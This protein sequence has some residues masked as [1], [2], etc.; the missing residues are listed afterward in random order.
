M[1]ST[2]SGTISTGAVAPV[3]TRN[4]K[5]FVLVVFAVMTPKLT[6]VHES[7]AARAFWV[8]KVIQGPLTVGQY[9]YVHASHLYG[10]T[11]AR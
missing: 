3:G 11:P 2:K 10:P 8:A 9:L 1:S 7:A 4:R 6:V 5:N